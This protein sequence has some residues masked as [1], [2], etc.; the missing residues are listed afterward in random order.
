MQSAKIQ[1]QTNKLNKHT[2]NFTKIIIKS[3]EN[4]NENS[5]ILN[6]NMK[7]EKSFDTQNIYNYHDVSQD[8]FT[9]DTIA[10]SKKNRS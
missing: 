10:S 4:L 2:S 3:K 1:T 9:N 8:E 7:R 5:Y 6:S